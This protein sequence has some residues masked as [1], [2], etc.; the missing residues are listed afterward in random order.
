MERKQQVGVVTAPL[1]A[2]TRAFLLLLLLA[3]AVPHSKSPQQACRQA[4]SVAVSRR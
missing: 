3:A 1:P 2:S 4:E